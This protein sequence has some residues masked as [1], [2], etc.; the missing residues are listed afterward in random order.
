VTAAVDQ[1][2]PE[3]SICIDCGLCCDGTFLVRGHIFP[4]EDAEALSMGKVQTLELEGKPY[5]KQPCPHFAGGCCSIYEK[6]FTVCRT[7]RCKLLR[8][9]ERGE[10][11]F[12][13]AR[14]AI[15][16]AKSLIAAVSAS[17]PAAAKCAER[18]RLR[19]ELAEIRGSAS[20]DEGAQIAKRLLNIIALDEFMKSRFKRRDEAAETT[21]TENR[22]R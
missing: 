18:I 5:F 16:T 19:A 6:R 22:Q 3:A 1:D 4:E 15:A 7:Y 9:Y 2:K 21:G 12:A 13:E 17:D 11:D 20:P 8:Q 10:I 14:E